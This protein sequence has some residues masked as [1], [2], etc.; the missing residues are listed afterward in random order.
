LSD[1]SSRLHQPVN[2][3]NM[4]LSAQPLPHGRLCRLDFVILVAGIA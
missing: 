3:D 1:S 2:D 4:T